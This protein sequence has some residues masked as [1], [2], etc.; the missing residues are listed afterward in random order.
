MEV[1]FLK[2]RACRLSR[3]D[4]FVHRHVSFAVA[5]FA[6]ITIVCFIPHIA[7]FNQSAICASRILDISMSGADGDDWFH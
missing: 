6:S 2:T 7:T 4:L 5:A 1:H 3:R